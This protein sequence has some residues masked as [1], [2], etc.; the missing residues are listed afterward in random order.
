[1][2]A[3]TAVAH[4]ARCAAARGASGGVSAPAGGAVRAALRASAGTL[5]ARRWFSAKDDGGATV[6]DVGAAAPG[7]ADEAAGSGGTGGGAAAATFKT[8]DGAASET[9]GF[10]A[11]TRQ[12]LD[13][14]T[15]SLYTDKEVFMRELVSNGSDALEKLR[16]LQVTGVETAQPE[17]PLEIRIVRDEVGNT[18]TI[19]DTGIG[20]TREEMI[21]SLGTIARSGSKA[22]VQNLKDSGD[23]SGGAAEGIIGQFGV[24]FYS[25]FMVAERV[26]VFSRSARELGEPA[27]CW[28][29]DGSGEY[30]IAEAEGVDRGTSIVIHLKAEQSEYTGATRVESV[31]KKYSNF[32]NFPIVLDGDAINT[33]D[34]LWTQSKQDITEE[35]Y[36]EFYRFIANAFDEPLYTLHFQADAPI[37]LQTLFFVPS[38][39]SEKYGMGRMAPGVD[40]YSRKVLIE[41]K[42]KDIL[43]EWLRFVKGVVDSEDL[44]LAISREKP[45]DSRL[46]VRIR[47]VL[48]RRLL[49]FFE[50]NMQKEREAYEAFY[51]EYGQFLKEGVCTDFSNKEAIAKLLLFESSGLE[52]GAQTS[53]DEYMT[54]QKPTQEKIYY[55]L[56][57]DRAMA[58]ASP[59]YEAFKKS[60]T[61]CLFLY[62]A[63]DDFVMNNLT[64]YNGRKLVSAES[65]DVDLGADAS[66]G[67]E[68]ED[69]AEVKAANEALT[70]W[71]TTA[72][73]KRVRKVETTTRLVDSPAI[74]TDHESAAL[75]RM[76][77]MVDTSS[78][79][80]AGSQLPMQNLEV[81]PKHPLIL[82]LNQARESNPELAAEVAEQVLDNALVSA[83]LMDDSRVMLPRI[84]KLL[85]VVLGTAS[86]K[87]E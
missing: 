30:S 49:R 3:R 37:S 83:G 84:N 80:N 33:V 81:N 4:I 23:V 47:E 55:L 5:P 56:A 73:A 39:H 8:K 46:L 69:T 26:E 31:V 60:G 71:L 85:E 16:H 68:E 72:L 21:S 38:Q 32:V 64:T 70:A 77:Q 18:L 65:N 51:A 29:S 43:P 36:S 67:A 87:D 42:C 19:S 11:E 41:S 24:G 14:V 40:L 1:M 61:E 76:M 44:P 2:I 45:Q 78:G 62:S 6:V 86:A 13:I 20:F 34:A 59:Y 22:F 7:E 75:R 9:L 12:L 35:K 74:V 58:E 25:A 27:H 79:G 17:L 52:A 50:Q 28:S 15:N 54:R 82:L 63:I 10:Q 66:E 57:P 48:L 53:V